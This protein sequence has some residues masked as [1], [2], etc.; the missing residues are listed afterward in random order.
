MHVYKIVHGG[1]FKKNNNFNFTKLLLLC[2]P[3]YKFS[4][5]ILTEMKTKKTIF[6]CSFEI[7]GVTYV[8]RQFLRWL[9][10]F[11]KRRESPQFCKRRLGLLTDHKNQLCVLFSESPAEAATFLVSAKTSVPL[12]KITDP[13]YSSVM[14]SRRN[15]RKDG[16]NTGLRGKNPLAETG[17]RPN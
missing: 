11:C 2:M 14:N 7:E 3:S 1:D 8:L 12:E 5:A 4:N 13:W 17:Q 9:K 16:A 6:I 10:K 15:H